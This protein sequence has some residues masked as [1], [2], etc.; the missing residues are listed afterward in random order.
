MAT[1][2][3]GTLRP[4]MFDHFQH[5]SGAIK[6]LSYKPKEGAEKHSLVH[7][8][9]KDIMLA[10]LTWTMMKQPIVHSNSIFCQVKEIKRLCADIGGNFADAKD[11]KLLGAAVIY[12]VSKKV[13]AILDAG[14]GGSES[15][16]C[17]KLNTTVIDNRIQVWI[18]YVR[19][20]SLLALLCFLTRRDPCN[21]RGNQMGA[22]NPGLQFHFKRVGWGF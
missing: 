1:I 19:S 20:R 6:T 5:G 15:K 14:V 12:F 11:P 13:E 21:L 9:M 4:M 17:L 10:C 16:W 2:T 7:H 22:S 8:R 18:S 3:I